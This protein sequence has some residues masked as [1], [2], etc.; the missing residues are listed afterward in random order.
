MSCVQVCAGGKWYISVSVTPCLLQCHLSFAQFLCPFIFSH[1]CHL[2]LCKLQYPETFLFFFF[3]YLRPHIKTW[4]LSSQ[5]GDR[6]ALRCDYTV[7][8]PLL[9]GT[10]DIKTHR[11]GFMTRHQFV[12]CWNKKNRKRKSISISV[13]VVVVVKEAAGKWS[14]TGTGS[15][16]SDKTYRCFIYIKVSKRS[17]SP[18][19]LK[20]ALL[21][22]VS[23]KNRC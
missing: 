4:P 22:D 15:G 14:F 12:C 19:W 11:A 16:Q 20:G 2:V 9:F 6:P 5:R 10:T 18:V 8:R 23:G 17:E 1:Y 7:V 21:C 3:L 13:T